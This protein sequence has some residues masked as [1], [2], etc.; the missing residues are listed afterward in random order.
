[1]T[2]ALD[3]AIETIHSA[4]ASI[5]SEIESITAEILRLE[6]E[7]RALPNRAASFSEL[8]KGILD[9]VKAAGERYADTQIR[10]TIIDFAKGAYRDQ[11][12][13]L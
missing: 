10:A 6:E 2:D 9:L 12:L 1:M 8:K 4:R 13:D 5:R 3:T 7:N 11:R